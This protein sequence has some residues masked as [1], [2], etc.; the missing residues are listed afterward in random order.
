[1]LAVAIVTGLAFGS[2]VPWGRSPGAVA[3]LVRVVAVL[4]LVAAAVVVW[5]IVSPDDDAPALAFALAGIAAALF[6][7]R[8]ERGA[9]AA[10]P[11]DRDFEL[12][13]R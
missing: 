9:D 7:G 4:V 6:A 12:E 1:M 8:L 3:I 13:P 2:L 10:A 11:A 5:P